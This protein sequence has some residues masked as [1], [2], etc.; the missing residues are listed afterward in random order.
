[1]ELKPEGGATG[2]G[3]GDNDDQ[4]GGQTGGRSGDNEQIQQMVPWRMMVKM[5]MHT[6]GAAIRKHLV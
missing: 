4:A 6:N 2:G 1:M 5:E 3:G